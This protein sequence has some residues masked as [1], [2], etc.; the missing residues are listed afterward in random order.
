MKCPWS[1]HSLI[2]LIESGYGFADNISSGCSLSTCSQIHP[3][4]SIMKILPNETHMLNSLWRL[5][6]FVMPPVLFT[7]VMVVLLLST[8]PNRLHSFTAIPFGDKAPI[9]FGQLLGIIY[10]SALRT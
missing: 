1:C 10:M 4:I 3:S 2:F 8:T 6:P 5:R 7:Q 9:T